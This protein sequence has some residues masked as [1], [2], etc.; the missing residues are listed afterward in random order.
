[1]SQVLIDSDLFSE[2]LAQKDPIVAVNA[3]KYFKEF[4]NYTISAM[5]FF[6][7]QKGLVFKPKPKITAVL[8][9]LIQDLVILRVRKE[10]A[11][12]GGT[13]H[14]LLKQ[15]G[16]TV[17]EADPVIAATAITYGLTLA[18]G[19]TKHYQFMIEAGFPIRLA[20]WRES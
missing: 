2:M 8:T 16:R 9:G 11:D 14:G 4:G 13:I 17:G 5:T 15:Q 12:L 19:N 6:E 18:T 3:A 20:N 1:M 7:S 10:E